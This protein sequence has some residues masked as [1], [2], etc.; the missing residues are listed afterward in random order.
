MGVEINPIRPSRGCMEADMQRLG[1]ILGQ[2][3]K[4][5]GWEARIYFWHIDEENSGLGVCTLDRER[6]E[7]GGMKRD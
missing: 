6:I 5:I 3:Y 4:Q 7:N 2:S 1:T